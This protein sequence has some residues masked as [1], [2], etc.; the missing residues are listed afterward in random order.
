M[1]ALC[2]EQE[3]FMQTVVYGYPLSLDPA[4]GQPIPAHPRWWPGNLA[5]RPSLNPAIVAID[6][7]NDNP[8]VSLVAIQFCLMEAQL[9]EK[10]GE[11]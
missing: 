7:F 1:K 8:P 2:R 3:R 5:W 11:G 6:T 10:I 9:Q 4:S